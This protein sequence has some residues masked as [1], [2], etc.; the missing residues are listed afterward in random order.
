MNIKVMNPEIYYKNNFYGLDKFSNHQYSLLKVEKHQKE[1]LN[2]FHKSNNVSAVKSRQI[3]MTSILALYVSYIM[4]WGNKKNIII[5][6]PNVQM[7]NMFLSKLKGVL[8]KESNY[9]MP[10]EDCRIYKDKL[11]YGDCL[12]KTVS[13]IN[14]MK[15]YNID[16]LIID[17][18]CFIEDLAGI[19]AAEALTTLARGGQVITTSSTGGIS[20]RI[21]EKWH[22]S[23]EKEFYTYKRELILEKSKNII[24]NNDSMFYRAK[25]N[26]K[27]LSKL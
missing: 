1:I 7:G 25:F 13:N 15:S 12:V 11:Y 2:L 6:S 20:D 10:S 4:L 23:V 3:G 8:F 19:F 17:E 5:C 26:Q 16:L 24:L 22:K 27:S 14:M 18:A 21:F 9:H